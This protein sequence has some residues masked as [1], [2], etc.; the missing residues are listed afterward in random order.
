MHHRGGGAS[1][2]RYVSPS[3]EREAIEAYVSDLEKELDGARARLAEIK[4]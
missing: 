3:E 4:K 1:W 2:R